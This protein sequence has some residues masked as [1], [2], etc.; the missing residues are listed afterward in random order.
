[1]GLLFD[2]LPDIHFCAKNLGGQS[3]LAPYREM[4]AVLSHLLTRYEEKIDFRQLA[5]LAPLSLNQFD[6]RF[7]RLF[8]LT[9]QQFWLRVRWIDARHLLSPQ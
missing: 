3:L 5:R 2:Y 7:K 1:M 4:E 8:Q 9:P 6:R